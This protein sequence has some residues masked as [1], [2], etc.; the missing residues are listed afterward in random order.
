MQRVV[1]QRQAR[2][3]SHFSEY[4][5]P[6]PSA[7]SLAGRLAGRHVGVHATVVAASVEQDHATPA[8]LTSCPFA[9]FDVHVAK[10]FLSAD[11]SVEFVEI[12]AVER[13]DV[14][15]LVGPDGT[16]AC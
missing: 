11:Q 1:A 2:L 5:A 16:L 9:A 4:G 6:I 13:R 15:V 7:K 14:I 10:Y 8:A 12:R 3:K